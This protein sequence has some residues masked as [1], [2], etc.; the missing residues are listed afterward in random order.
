MNADMRRLQALLAKGLLLDDESAE[1]EA[2]AA[3]LGV[4]LRRLRFDF[5]DP[6]AGWQVTGEIP[7]TCGLDRSM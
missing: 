1:V 3:R 2:L 5:T 7:P 6:D 4:R